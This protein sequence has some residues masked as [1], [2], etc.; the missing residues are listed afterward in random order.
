VA[1]SFE[2][3]DETS[4]KIGDNIKTKL[5]N[6]VYRR[7]PNLTGLRIGF[8]GGI[9]CSIKGGEYLHQLSDCQLLKNFAPWS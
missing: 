9:L 8:T 2:P 7:G 3:G 6:R 5:K 1:G 4:A